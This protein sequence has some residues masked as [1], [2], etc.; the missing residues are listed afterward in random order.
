MLVS[1]GFYGNWSTST[2]TVIMGVFRLIVIAIRATLEA[3]STGSLGDTAIFISML[4]RAN[5][6]SAAENLV[7]NFSKIIITSDNHH[8]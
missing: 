5:I 7:E 1:Y 2:D 8:D 6:Y 4:M 3:K